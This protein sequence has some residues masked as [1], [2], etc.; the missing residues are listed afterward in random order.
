MRRFPVGPVLAVSGWVA[1]AATALP[2]AAPLRVLAVT[3]FLLI[4]PGAAAARLAAR[5]DTRAGQQVRPVPVLAGAVLTVALSLTVATLV[6]EVFYL[7]RSFSTVRAMAALAALTTLLALSAVLVGGRPRP[8][9]L[10]SRLRRGP[11]P[12]VTALCLLM[13]ATACSG[14]SGRAPGSPVPTV[15]SASSPASAGSSASASVTP[16]APGDWHVVFQDDFNGSALD[17]AKWT[18]CYDW[19]LGGCTNAGNHESEWYLPGQVTVG[20]GVLSLTATR[21]TTVGA[22]G[23]T[24]PWTSGMVS[25]G[26]SDWY[27]TP[28]RTFN[29]GYFAASIKVPGDE[30][31]FPAFWLMPDT[32][33][34]PPELDVAE[35]SG[36][37]RTVQMT[38]HWAD[39]G[40]ADVH[41][42]GR[43]GQVDFPAGYHVFALDWEKTS[44]TWYVDGVERYRVTEHV[45]DIPMEMLLNLAVGFPAAPP[46]ALDSS[47]M[48]VD[49]VRVWQH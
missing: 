22:E 4:C 20:G 35:F 19:N 24:Y 28:R 11:G 49:W 17:S 10:S 16:A 29:G 42:D 30:G 45:P 41:E 21:R 7:T 13:T 5:L 23:S 3:G 38:V 2:A 15:P 12:G 36:T 6:A 18:T 43:Y 31:M 14:G 1:L 40:G 39:P 37:E 32:R 9:R 25:T 34:T 8:G 47:V 48:K 46:A 33:Y 44:L 27:G 26:R